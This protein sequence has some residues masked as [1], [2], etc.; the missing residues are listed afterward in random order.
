MIANTKDVDL[1]FHPCIRT[2]VN[3]KMSKIGNY[4]L[5]LEITYYLTFL[6]CMGFI[7][8]AA[9]GKPDPTK[10][11]SPYD[12]IR[13]AFEI[14]VIVYWVSLVISFVFGIVSSVTWEH[15]SGRGVG[16]ND[17]ENQVKKPTTL[18]VLY[19]SV[20]HLASDAFNYYSLFWIICLFLV[21]PLRAVSSPVQWIFAVFAVT[22]GFL[23]LIKIIR[24]LPGFGTYVH[25][26]TLIIYYDVPKFSL[27]CFTLILVL[28]ECF[29]LSLR[30]P[31]NTLR[32]DNLS[33]TELGEEGIDSEIHWAI[34]F[35]IRILLESQSIFMHNY[36]SNHLNWLSSIIYLFGLMLLIIILIN[37]FIAQVC[38]YPVVKDNHEI[39]Q[40][41]HP[42]VQQAPRDS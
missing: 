23:R 14:I 26:I 30:V 18:K 24:L 7:F 32:P 2:V 33:A 38:L 3:K 17:K 29:F 35:F 12:Y 42:G 8:I 21:A 25:T 1:A 4:F 41:F 20:T 16:T 27:V 11:D 13:A 19:R 15:H 22:F 40:V 6:F 5:L 37:I 9:A 39:S 28:A 36:L 31:Y 10:Y 34:L